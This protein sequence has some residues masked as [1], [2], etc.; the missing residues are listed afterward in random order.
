MTITFEN[1]AAEIAANIVAAQCQD[2]GMTNI[3]RN[4]DGTVWASM[5]DTDFLLRWDVTSQQVRILGRLRVAP[6]LKVP[7]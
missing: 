6:Q 1:R 7:A 2:L 3:S 4:E 5:G